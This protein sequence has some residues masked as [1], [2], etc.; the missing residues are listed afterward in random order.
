M[1]VGAIAAPAGAHRPLAGPALGGGLG[2]LPAT[3]GGGGY[4]PLW[5]VLLVV[6]RDLLI[7]GGA[8]LVHALTHRLEMQPLWISK[9]NTALQIGLA[10]LVLAQPAPDG[11][12]GQ[13]VP[14]LI[15]AAAATT[16]ASGGAYT[17]TWLKRLHQWEQGK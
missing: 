2:A 3:L 4:L 10:A 16:V 17:I 15:Y 12:A 9:L 11:L 8:L 13:V 5:L 6:F 1:G 7:V 14:V